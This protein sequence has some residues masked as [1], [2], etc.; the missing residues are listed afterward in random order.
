MRDVATQVGIT[1]RAVQRIIHDLVE[2]GYV[3]A[4]KCGRRNHYEPVL[5]AHLRHPLES[6]VT[7]KQLL[8]GLAGAGLSP[9]P[10]ADE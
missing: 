2:E 8:S 10:D 5:G 3:V 7:I 6:R 9:V 4:S 1:E